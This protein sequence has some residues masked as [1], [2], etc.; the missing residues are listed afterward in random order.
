MPF[1]SKIWQNFS[2]TSVDSNLAI[3][4]VIFNNENDFPSVRKS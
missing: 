2:K 4:S 3:E 1:F